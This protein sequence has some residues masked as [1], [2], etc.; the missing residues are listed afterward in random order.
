MS[1]GEPQATGEPKAMSLSQ[2]GAE[3]SENMET[4]LRVFKREPQH[5]YSFKTVLFS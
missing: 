1:T 3:E 4:S 5:R 2:N